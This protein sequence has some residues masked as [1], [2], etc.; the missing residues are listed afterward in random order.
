LPAT[1]V[2]KIKTNS[3]IVGDYNAQLH[4]CVICSFRC[5]NFRLDI[6]GM[7]KVKVAL[8]DTKDADE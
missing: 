2:S 7:L 5:L 8:L 4:M 1:S 3:L 6:V